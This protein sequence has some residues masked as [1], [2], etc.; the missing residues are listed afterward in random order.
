MGGKLYVGKETEQPDRNRSANIVLELVAPFKYTGRTIVTDRGFSC[1]ELSMDLHE[2][3]LNHVGTVKPC[4]IGIPKDMEKVD[5][6][7]KKP[8]NKNNNSKNKDKSNST[9]QRMDNTMDQTISNVISQINNANTSGPAVETAVEP[10]SGF[11]YCKHMTL[12]KYHEVG[13]KNPCYLLSS[14][15]RLPQ[16][17]LFDQKPTAIHFYNHH[18][19][20]VD[21]L[22]Q[23]VKEYSTKRTNERWPMRMFYWALDIA[24]AQSFIAYKLANPDICKDIHY[25]KKFLLTLALRLLHPINKKRREDVKCNGHLKN[26]YQLEHNM[27]KMMRTVPVNRSLTI[28]QLEN[29][30]RRVEPVQIQCVP[31]RL[32]YSES[33]KNKR[34]QGR[35]YCF[36]YPS[37]GKGGRG[38]V[39]CLQCDSTCCPKHRVCVECGRVRECC[40]KHKKQKDACV[41]C[42]KD[43]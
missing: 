29:F 39:T 31:R 34:M 12:V 13:K 43:M 1:P 7:P 8:R 19:Y 38:K 2:M 36:K 21:L 6:K 27:R 35:K 30:H 26:V 41:D 3:G 16:L 15:H 25:R 28:D 42:Y 40:K 4:R 22:D 17:S 33:N 5:L 24:A 14:L 11:V 20:G 23:L 18:K 9:A 37:C 32:S 10:Q